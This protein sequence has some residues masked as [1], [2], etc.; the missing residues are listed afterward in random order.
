MKK[1]HTYLCPLTLRHST[2]AYER[3][4]IF[5]SSFYTTPLSS[6]NNFEY[7]IRADICISEDNKFMGGKKNPKKPR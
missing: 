7:A 1:A 2:Q 4:S 3:T 6:L 5:K